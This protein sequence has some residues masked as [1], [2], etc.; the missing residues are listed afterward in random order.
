MSSRYKDL[1][2]TSQAVSVAYTKALRQGELVCWR[3]RNPKR[4]RKEGEGRVVGVR[5][6]EVQ[7]AYE[8][9]TLLVKHSTNPPL[10]CKEL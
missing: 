5:T 3:A 4:L 8:L 2:K 1:G 7:G 9:R 10:N 6:G